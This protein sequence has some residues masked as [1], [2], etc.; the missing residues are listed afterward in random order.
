MISQ[1]IKVASA[2]SKFVNI[3]LSTQYTLSG[4]RIALQR[5]HSNV[6]AHRTCYLVP[7]T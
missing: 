6:L 1:P 2:A 5:T 7:R 4:F 3:L